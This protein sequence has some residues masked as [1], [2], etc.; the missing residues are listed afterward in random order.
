MYNYLSSS[1]ILYLVNLTKIIRIFYLWTESNTI[2]CTFLLT[3]GY[4]LQFKHLYSM[5]IH[6][7]QA[8]DY[9]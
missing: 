3:Q 1:N 7:S 8:P 9:L 6:K 4:L 2:L 5:C